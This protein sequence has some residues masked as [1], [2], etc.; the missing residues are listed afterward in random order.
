MTSRDVRVCLIPHPPVMRLLLDLRRIALRSRAASSQ[1]LLAAATRSGLS[2]SPSTSR[3]RLSS[4]A[5]FSLGHGWS[6][7][8]GLERGSHASQVCRPTVYPAG[9]LVGSESRRSID[10]HSPTPS[11]T[12]L[13]FRQVEQIM[14]QLSSSGDRSGY[15]F[16]HPQ[17]W[18][19]ADRASLPTIRRDRNERSPEGC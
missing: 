7:R 12:F 5:Q 10:Q 16:R 11:R 19:Q 15:W 3:A 17:S 1:S 18:R 13:Q 4:S 6:F 14:P 2:L 9:P 8:G